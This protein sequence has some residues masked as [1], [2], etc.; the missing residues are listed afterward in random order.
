VE[1]AREEGKTIL[2]ELP[3]REPG[4]S[5]P[6]VITVDFEDSMGARRQGYA[7]VHSSSGQRRY[8]V[9]D[10]LP[11]FY[12]PTRPADLRLRTF[13]NWA[14][15]IGVGLFGTVFVVVGLLRL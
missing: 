14:A 10:R 12:D 11:V 3:D 5:E 9:G 1:R 8:E 13:W 2:T 4:E 7:E 6:W 15:P